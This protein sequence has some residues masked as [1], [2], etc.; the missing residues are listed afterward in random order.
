MKKERLIKM[1][2]AAV[3]LSLGIILPTWLGSMKEINDT[4]LPIHLAAMFC[5]IIC[6]KWYGLLVGFLI[7]VM[8]S[9]IF[10]MPVLYPRGLYMA[11]EAATYG[12]VIGFMYYLLKKKPAWYIYTCILTAQIAGRIVWAL[13]KNILLGFGEKGVTFNAFIAEGF[14]DALPGIALQLI[15]IPL[16][17]SIIDDVKAR[18]S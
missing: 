1:I 2:L 15:L 18:I 8:R 7:P 3:F 6:G 5:G 14:I 9:L 16:V 17:V 4:I 10:A 11:F 13:A 12:F